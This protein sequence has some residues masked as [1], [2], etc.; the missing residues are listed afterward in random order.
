MSGVCR[1]WFVFS[2]NE[3]LILEKVPNKGRRRRK[4]VPGGVN[5]GEDERGKRWR[6]MYNDVFK[7]GRLRFVYK[8]IT[9]SELISH[10]GVW[11]IIIATEGKRLRDARRETMR[12]YNWLFA[13]ADY[14]NL[15]D[16]LSFY[17]YV[18]AHQMCP[19]LTFGKVTTSVFNMEI[20]IIYCKIIWKNVLTS[21]FI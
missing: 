6:K 1:C 12:L 10:M 11:L 9:R 2:Q 19:V 7:S 18:P 15:L 3:R 21:V 13:V 17:D 14:D 4:T 16:S 8:G 5:W 20:I